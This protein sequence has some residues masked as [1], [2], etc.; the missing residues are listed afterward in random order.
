M[1]FKSF[2][3]ALRLILKYCSIYAGRTQE[4]TAQIV[5]KKNHLQF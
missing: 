3:Q 5:I 1:N 2:H 4:N